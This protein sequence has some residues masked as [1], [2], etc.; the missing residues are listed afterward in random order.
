MTNIF[1]NAAELKRFPS[2][3]FNYTR[4]L[5]NAGWEGGLSKLRADSYLT[6]MATSMSSAHRTTLLPPTHQKHCQFVKFTPLRSVHHNNLRAYMWQFSYRFQFFLFKVVVIDAGSKHFVELLSRLVCLLTI[7]FHTFLG[8]TF[9]LVGPRRKTFPSMVIFQLLLRKFE[10]QT[11]LN[12]C[13]QHLCSTC[14]NKSIQSHHNP[15]VLLSWSNW[16]RVRNL[17]APRQRV[18]PICRE[19]SYS[20]HISATAP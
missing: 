12:C 20:S 11:W 6:K 18:A 4:C 16:A 15:K 13:P 9:H 3:S 2:H 8:M 10:I 5:H 14:W 7:S 19:V 17:I 1:L